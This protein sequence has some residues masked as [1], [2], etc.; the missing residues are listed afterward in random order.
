MEIKDLIDK[1]KENPNMNQC[2]MILTHIGIVRETSRDGKKISQ[3]NINPNFD[4]I[5]SI[6]EKNKHLPGVIDIKVWMHEKGTLNVGDEIMMI[7]IAGN[8]RENTLSAMTKTL[9]EIK[10]KAVVKQHIF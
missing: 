9:N 5:D 6:I 4:I 7:A 10:E 3:L 1:L 8:I 2:G